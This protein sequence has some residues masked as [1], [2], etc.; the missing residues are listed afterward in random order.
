MSP[1]RDV[2]LITDGG[3]LG[4]LPLQAAGELGVLGARIIAVGLGDEVTGQPIPDPDADGGYLQH[5]GQPVLTALDA[6]A[7]REL[8][9]V[10]PGGRYVNVAT[11]NFD[12]G[13]LYTQLIA[14]ADRQLLERTEREVFQERF[15]PFLAAALVLLALEFL[16]P[17][18]IRRRRRR[19]R[20]AGA[21]HPPAVA[22]VLFALAAAL[23]APATARAVGVPEQAER[24]GRQAFA[25]GRF[26]RRREQPSAPRR[27]PAP[28]WRSCS[29]TAASP[30][31]VRATSSSAAGLLR[32]AVEQARRPE[33][34]GCRP[35]S[36]WAISGCGGSS[37]C[38]ASRAAH[39]TIRRRRSRA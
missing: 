33:L 3:D 2:V 26:G 32:Q 31:I 21:A 6:E 30:P 13:V 14:G 9:G 16:L 8:A 37:R 27:R 22:V 15:Q 38:S 18:L 7:L 28:G 10:T 24:D 25:D 4:S 35:L 23:V 17:D 1:Y 20:R 19:G 5:E 29:T 34:A 12:L 36:R 39:R 11:G